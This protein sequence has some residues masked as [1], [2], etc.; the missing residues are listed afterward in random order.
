V[1]ADRLTERLPRAT[2]D[3][4]TMTERT[5]IMPRLLGGRV[6]RD[7]YVRLLASLHAIYASLERALADPRVRALAPLPILHRTEALARD[8]ADYGAAPATAVPAPVAADYA[9]HVDTLVNTDPLRVAAHAYVRYLGDLSGG[10]LLRG[11]V[12]RA[13]HLPPGRGIAFYELGDPAAVARTKAGIRAILDALPPERHDDIVAE[14]RA[15]FERHVEL[16]A[17]IPAGES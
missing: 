3:L 10:Q 11:I 2:R 15:A 9:A 4:H 6:G 16:F 8:L 14:A 12:A 7:E 1:N 13:G 5:G 17:A